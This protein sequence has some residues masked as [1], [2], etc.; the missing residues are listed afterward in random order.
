[1]LV[2]AVG[3]TIDK[4]A[5]NFLHA[6][7]YAK[8]KCMTMQHKCLGPPTIPFAPFGILYI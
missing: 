3:M 2:M 4:T 7:G 5:V 1:M 8:L 6:K